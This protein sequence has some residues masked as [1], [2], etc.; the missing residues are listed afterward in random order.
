MTVLGSRSVCFPNGAIFF[1]HLSAQSSACSE[2]TKSDEQHPLLLVWGSIFLARKKAIFH[3]IGQLCWIDIYFHQSN[4]IQHTAAHHV[5]RCRLISHFSSPMKSCFRFNIF[6]VFTQNALRL[7]QQT[8]SGT[9]FGGEL[10]ICWKMDCLRFIFPPPPPI[11]LSFDGKMLYSCTPY[12][13]VLNLRIYDKKSKDK[14]SKGQ[15][16]LPL[17]PWW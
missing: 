2:Y 9:Y 8:H 15:E 5:L 11:R 1:F 14:R 13:N 12:Y 16:Y 3:F 4:K 17:I 7:R 10:R 6:L